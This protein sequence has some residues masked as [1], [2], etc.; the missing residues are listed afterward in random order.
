MKVTDVELEALRARAGEAK[1]SVPRLLVESALARGGDSVTARDQLATELFATH[2]TLAGAARNM[3][4][5]ARKAN[6]IHEVPT[7]FG[8]VFEDL[9][10]VGMKLEQVVDGLIAANRRD[11]LEVGAP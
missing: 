10:R 6:T 2:R 4:Q 5:V 9:R 11:G 7:D 8:A 1:V 3:N